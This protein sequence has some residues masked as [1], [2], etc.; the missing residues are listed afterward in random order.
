MGMVGG[1]IFTIYASL[2]PSAFSIGG[3]LLALGLMGM[4]R[5][6]HRLMNLRD[7][8]RITL[9][10]EMIMLVM[11]LYFLLFSNQPI[12]A[13]IIYGAYQ[14]SYAFGGYLMRAETHFAKKIRIMEWMDVVRQQGYL[15][16]LALSYGFYKLLEF[17]GVMEAKTQVYYLHFRLLILQL[18]IIIFLINSFRRRKI[19]KGLT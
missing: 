9:L 14:F 8:F 5:I 11:I 19:S 1:S 10:T 18:I 7:F 12:V 17:Y 13:I 4:A 3:I 16:G 6:Y 15:I 2:S